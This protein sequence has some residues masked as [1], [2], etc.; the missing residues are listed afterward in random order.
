VLRVASVPSSHL[1]VRHLSHPDGRDAVCRLP[2]PVPADGRKVPGGWWP[3]VMLE[4]TWI[5]RNHR[6]FDVFH[7]HFGFDAIDTEV[8]EDVVHELRLRRKPF[9]YTVHDLRNPHHPEPHAHVAQLDVLMPAADEVLTLTQGAAQDIKARWSRDATV[10]PHPHILD[11]AR[12]ECA[13]PATQRFVIGVHVKSLRANMDPFPVLDAL[14]ETVAELDGAVL[15]INVHDEIFQP[16]NHWYAPRA[17]AALR[18]YADRP[19]VEVRVH[20]YFSDAELWDYLSALSVSVLPYRFG[21]HSGWLEACFD[22]GTA[23]IAPRCGFYDQQHPCETYDFTEDTFAAE[24]LDRAARTLYL[25]HCDAQTAARATWAQRRAER[26]RL[27]SAHRRVYES[28]M[29]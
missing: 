1:Y 16:G 6:R 11:R 23:V 26:V 12:I 28:V 19:R 4:P 2:D 3:P 8:L 9:I 27:A 20:P 29:R 14:A 17:G 22:L 15:Q 18:A 21:T 10:L 5:A 7:L 13:R 24:S 25:R